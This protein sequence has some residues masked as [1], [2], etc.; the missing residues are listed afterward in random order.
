MWRPAIFR[1][2]SPLPL[3]SLTF[4]GK[5]NG[6]I[7][8]TTGN[9]PDKKNNHWGD[10]NVR[11]SALCLLLGIG[12]SSA[13]TLPSFAQD[14]APAT[15]LVPPGVRSSMATRWPNVAN[16]R[17]TD[18]G[19]GVACNLVATYG[20]EQP[21]GL[22]AVPYGRGI[23]PQDTAGDLMPK[24]VAATAPAAGRG[25]AAGGGGGGVPL[26]AAGI[27]QRGT[28]IPNAPLLPYEIVP[29][30]QPPNGT[31]FANVASV[32]LLKNGHLLVFQ[33]MPMYQLLEYDQNN[34]LLRSIDP[35]LVS[36]PHAMYV[37]KDQNV[38]LSDQQCGTA[39]KINLQ[40][41]VLMRL[42]TAGKTPV[43]HDAD[44]DHFFNEPTAIAIGPKGDIYV[45]TGHGGPDPRVVKFDKTGKFLTT[46]TMKHP[47]GSP[48][49]IHTVAVDRSG[50]VFVGDRDAKKLFIFDP[51]GK[52]LKMVQMP[53]MVCEL[54]LDAK[55]QLWMT[56]G[57]DGQFMRLDK[58]GNILGYLGKEGFAADEYGEA[59]AITMT[60]DG[61]TIYVSDTVNND[62]K[63]YRRKD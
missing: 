13:A 43:W 54:Y 16:P 28:I 32:A 44:G 36:R 53:D 51:N 26:G 62:I 21:Q 19:A 42:G 31:Q 8:S 39:V 24:P 50:T 49:I 15:P 38:W 34:R 52:L 12:L 29:G 11:R 33:R 41:D 9:V 47:D 5:P 22:P 63:R 59:H 55:D 3:P 45:T 17:G 18:S 30:P 60:P 2:K 58:Q 37:D 23:A 7:V 6:P 14:A 4:A 35:N 61:K 46:W 57:M 48:A 1:Q 56:S 27:A 25:A 10:I 40:G 20:A